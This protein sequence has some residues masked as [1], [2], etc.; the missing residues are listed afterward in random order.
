MNLLS[1]GGSDPSSGAGI[2]SDIKT[3][4]TLNV[5]GLT[6]VTAITSQ[7]T[8][9]FGNVE[10]VSQK[11]LKNQIES[12]MADFK[13]DGIKIGMVYNS[14]IIKI[15]SKQLQKLKIPIVVDPVI[16]S[17][18]GGALIEKSAMI[19]FQKYI[20][21][22][23][24]VITPNRFEA[25]ILSKIKINSK[26]SLRSAAK[27]IQKMGAKN[28]VITG[29]ETGSKG[30]SDFIF[31]KNK[32][33][34]ISGDK[35][36]LSNHGSGCNYS[37]AVIFAL[38]KN[39][40]IKESLRFAQ[41]FTQNSIKNARKIGKGIAVTDVQ[42][43]IS[44][45]LSDAIEKFVHIKNIYKNIPECQINFVYSKQKPKSPEDILG[46]SGRIV[47]SGKEALVAG[48]LT[49]GGS[50]HV[51][52]ALLT[53][54]KK[55][56]KIRSAINLKY[57]DKTILKIKKSK[58]CISSYDRTE[59]PKNVKNKGSTIEW[60]IKKAVKDS[61]KMPDVIY[62]KGDF[63]KEPMIIVFGETPEKVLKK[64]LKII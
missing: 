61:T 36:N 47:K 26:K 32:E 9:S 46:I 3:F 23:A 45:D 20:I 37:A 63:G 33:C 40:T 11:I 41:Q 49:Y 34:F 19:D 4:S 8:S 43:Y 10:P 56:P 60:G 42:D 12:V 52:T 30:I 29:I 35:I 64:I 16:K 25:E 17:T 1:I 24:T 39:K 22:L 50:K 51:A 21:P 27:K 7:N 44:K 15:L 58:L 62:H 6:I 53:M 59:E 14:Q 57:Q 5:H 48:E 38:A 31:E 18:T 13:I 2:Q 28:V 54:N 55:Y